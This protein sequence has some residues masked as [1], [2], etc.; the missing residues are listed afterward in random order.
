M[1]T[2][3]YTS[4]VEN[5]WQK[6]L[7]ISVG[8]DGDSSRLPKDV[9]ATGTTEAVLEFHRLI[10]EATRDQ[11][12]AYKPQIAGY[13]AMGTAGFEAL[14]ETVRLARE[15]APEVPII[16]DAKRADIGSTNESYAKAAF[17]VIGAD[18]IT[19]H[20]YLGLE[21]MKPF[22][23]RTDKGVIVLCRTSNPGAGRYQDLDIDGRPLYQHIADDVATNW[24]TNGNCGLVVGA[25]YPDELRQVRSIAPEI[26]LLIPGIGAQGGDVEQSVKSGLTAKRDGILLH[27][28]RS[29]MYAYE[30]HPSMSTSEAIRHE[31]NVLHEQIAAALP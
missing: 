2:P 13:E 31:M 20:P 25:T 19:V 23:E 7:F 28:S 4:Q 24:N 17:D 30:K 3:S 11:A 26:P 12:A 10:I 6:R 1:T 8:L 22:L 14:I 9:Q 16:L 29:I 27:A 5:R 15:L 18:A 21:T